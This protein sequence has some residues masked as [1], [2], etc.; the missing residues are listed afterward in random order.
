MSSLF[1]QNLF[2]NSEARATRQTASA[3]SS[4]D[5]WARASANTFADGAAYGKDPKEHAMSESSPKL[6]SGARGVVHFPSATEQP[7]FKSAGKL[8]GRIAAFLMAAGALVHGAAAQSAGDK[9]MVSIV[10]PAF[11]SIHKGGNVEIGIKFAGRASQETFHASVDGT[12][13]TQSFQ[14]SS[15]CSGGKQCDMQAFVPQSD[16]LI[17]TNIV[18]ASVIGSDESASIARVQFEFKPD[19]VPAGEVVTHLTPAVAIQAVS[20]T[21]SNA[22]D[23]N[24]YSV[25]IGPGPG[26]ARTAYTPSG[27][28]CS[29]SGSMFVLAL[30]RHTLTPDTTVGNGTGKFCESN[31]SGQLAGRLQSIPQG[32]VVIMHSFNGTVASLNTTAVGG[33]DFIKAGIVQYAYN[34]IGIAGEPAGTAYES[35][36]PQATSGATA[37]IVPLIGSLILDIQQ[38]YSFTSSQFGS[39]KVTPNNAN[40][41][42]YTTVTYNG[43]PVA[44]VGPDGNT[45]GGFMIVAVDRRTGVCWD[46]YV[47]PTNSTN[48]ATSAQAIG[49]LGWLLTGYYQRKDLLFITTFGTPFSSASSVNSGLVSI[50]NSLGGS[51]VV[52]PLLTTDGAT[53]TLLTSPDPDY[54]KG[55]NAVESSSLFGGAQTGELDGNLSRDKKNLWTVESAASDDTNPLNFEWT[56]VAF[57]QPQDW[58]AWTSG[59]EKAY[60]DLIS[61]A[62]HYPAIR[63]GLGCS[64]NDQDGKPNECAPIRSYYGAGF[65]GSGTAPSVLSLPYSSLTY[66]PNTDYTAADFTAVI[67]QLQIEA[68]LERN[69]YSVYSLFQPLASSRE[70]QLSAQ[71]KSVADNI[72]GSVAN[73][74]SVILVKRLTQ[75]SGA[76]KILSITPGIGPAFGALS[77]VLEGV[78]KLVPTSSGYPDDG[79]YGYTLEKLKNHSTAVNLEMQSSLATMFTSISADWAKLS[80]IGGGYGRQQLPWFM[81]SDCGLD[82]KVPIAAL[83]AMALL[84]KQQFYLTLLPKVFKIDTFTNQKYNT[85]SKMGYYVG[86]GLNRV[87]RSAYANIQQP[88]Y[89]SFAN[90]GTPANYDIYILAQNDP[91]WDWLHI[92]ATYKTANS[93]LLKDLFDEPTKEGVGLGGGAGFTN[94]QLMPSFGYMTS[95]AGYRPGTTCNP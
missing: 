9:S 16:L 1:R 43:A 68:G 45:R 37:P 32:D 3:P 47:L 20:F 46:Q 4:A 35:Y 59:Q 94:Y 10:T 57:Q 51:G 77:T 33:T 11:N 39:V 26:F 24:S 52:L 65:G 48:P 95:R 18:N 67:N 40:D 12:D 78:S 72:D 27:L 82:S 91:S 38:D 34:A 41:S 87:C 63:M 14:Y 8:L 71:L 92:E 55:H 73:N 28:S 80:T 84:E 5:A 19:F 53:Y 62:D 93:A 90:V 88:G 31:G 7:Q 29:T 66:Y 76:T 79:S 69:L 70:S 22:S 23:P 86:S 15:Q 50:F 17:G 36:Q 85:P 81:C 83:P 89:W 42:G 13:I 74:D 49:D 75:A 30:K 25:V 58:P 44:R 54:V 56:R 2:L 64:G 21:G 6:G 60:Q 61:T